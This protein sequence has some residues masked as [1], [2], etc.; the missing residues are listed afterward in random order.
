MSY[1]EQIQDL[2]GKITELRAEYSAMVAQP[3]CRDEVSRLVRDGVQDAAGVGERQ[4]ARTLAQLAAGLPVDLLAVNVSA[5]TAQGPV[6]VRI[7]LLPVMVRLLGA[8]AVRKALTAGVDAIPEGL[9]S[10]AR[11]ERLAAVTAELVDLQTKE[12]NLIREAADAGQDIPRR[13]DAGA[14]FVL[15]LDTTAVD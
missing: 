1:A 5:M 3:R 13:P 10:D 4:T 6:Q 15:A 9:P 11:A 7:D 14:R 2:R 12:E 8:A